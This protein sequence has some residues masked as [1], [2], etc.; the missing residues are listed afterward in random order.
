MAKKSEREPSKRDIIRMS[1]FFN[2]LLAAMIA[3]AWG[4]SGA[5]QQAPKPTPIPDTPTPLSLD[6]ELMKEFESNTDID[7][8]EEYTQAI[9]ATHSAVMD[10][11][12][13][14]LIEEGFP[15]TVID[16]TVSIGVQFEGNENAWGSGTVAV[17]EF[18]GKKYWVVF[19]AGHLL[20]GRD[21]AHPR[22]IE[23]S[24]I[25]VRDDW[26]PKPGT[27]SEAPFRYGSAARFDGKLKRDIGILVLPFEEERMMALF[28]ADA[29]VQEDQLCFLKPEEMTSGSFYAMG[30]PFLTGFR[31]MVIEDARINSSEMW[32]YG[33]DNNGLFVDD[34]LPSQGFSGGGLFWKTGEEVAYV[35]PVDLGTD[36]PSFN[37]IYSDNAGITTLSWLGEQGFQDILAEAVADLQAKKDALK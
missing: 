32:V 6:P 5:R 15:R 35:G 24:I 12:W 11:G 27:A 26:L 30:F 23:R 8:N 10:K 31:A 20:A 2:I 1:V 18:E 4:V 25:L 34:A 17:V 21:P 33:D 7:T 28:D 22:Q 14:K 13:E 37:P 3:V 29:V 16:S 36:D 19:T 9:E